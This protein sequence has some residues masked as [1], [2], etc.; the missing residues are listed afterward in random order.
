M[1]IRSSGNLLE[2]SAEAYV[3]TVNTVG[4]MGKG[5]ALQF[6]Q[7]FPDVFKQYAKDSKL[8]EV[9]VGSMHVVPVE[10]LTNPKYVINFPTKEH[11]KNPSKMNYIDLGLQDL[12]KTITE[13]RIQTIAIP[14]LGCGNGGLEW[15]S[16]R[17]KIEQAFKDVPV[18]VHLYGPAGSPLPDKMKI[19][20]TEPRMTKGRALLLSLMDSYSG[21]GYRLSHLEIQKLAYFLQEVG[22]PMKLRFQKNKYGPYADSLNHVLQ[23]IEG[24]FIRGYG[25]RSSEAEI[26]LLED[27]ADHAIAFLRRDRESL[28]RLKKVN[29]II[30]GFE[31]PYGMELLA[32]VHWVV[33]QYPERSMDLSFVTE[34]V[35]NWSNRKK[36][37]FSAKHIEKVWRYLLSLNRAS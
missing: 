5:I 11:W 24:H 17:V 30:Q 9:K 13:L 27:A 3:N 15:E 37:L 31:T 22:E 14:P 32:T 21:P 19:G 1:I 4:V 2:D 25:D 7:A 33:K 35:Q 26:Y 12:V 28:K 16:V 18:E 23:R 36:E 8:G 29:E 6:K 10:G 20:T 34:Q